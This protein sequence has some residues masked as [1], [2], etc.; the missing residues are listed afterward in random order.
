MEGNGKGFNSV[1]ETERLKRDC[2]KCG[3]ILERN[4]SCHKCGDTV[5]IEARQQGALISPIKD[6]IYN[7]GSVKRAVEFVKK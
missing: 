2:S 6:S 7:H 1:V 4:S 3:D 5:S